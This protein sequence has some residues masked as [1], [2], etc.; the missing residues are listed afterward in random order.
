M[1]WLH[2]VP[3]LIAPTSP[4][5][6]RYEKPIVCIFKSRTFI[7]HL[8]EITSAIKKTILVMVCGASFYAYGFT[9]DPKH[10]PFHCYLDLHQKIAMSSALKAYII[11]LNILLDD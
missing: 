5:A 7:L 10:L 4:F 3:Q 6:L 2:E 11:I 8:N 9:G 1:H